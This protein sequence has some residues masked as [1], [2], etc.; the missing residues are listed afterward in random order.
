MK[1]DPYASIL[2][3]HTQTGLCALFFNKDVLGG[4]NILVQ[5]KNAIPLKCANAIM[6]SPLA[7]LFSDA[8]SLHLIELVMTAMFSG[9]PDNEYSYKS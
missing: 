2:S 6:D 3:E 1:Y 9:D 4:N 5:D 8:F 7:K